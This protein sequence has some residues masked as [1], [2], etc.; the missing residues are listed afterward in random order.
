MIFADE[1]ECRFLRPAV[2][3]EE[4][5]HVRVVAD[6]AIA[7]PGT[8]VGSARCRR[9]DHQIM[10]PA[11]QFDWTGSFDIGGVLNDVAAVAS[12]ILE[13][14]RS[15]HGIGP[16]AAGRPEDTIVAVATMVERY[17]EIPA[18][19]ELVDERGKI[20]VCV[21]VAAAPL[22]CRIRGNVP[23]GAR[24]VAVKHRQARP[25]RPSRQIALV[26]GADRQGRVV[27]DIGFEHAVERKLAFLIVIQI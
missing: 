24:A 4:V 8:F 10:F 16:T 12:D 18:I 21:G 2:P 3:I 6:A 15:R 7:V 20:V 22:R 11:E 25:A 19:V 17:I 13:D 26:V 27:G 5:G 1:V 9:A 23:I 14:A